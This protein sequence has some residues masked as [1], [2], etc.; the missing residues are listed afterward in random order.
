MALRV[1]VLKQGPNLT[2]RRVDERLAQAI[3]FCEEMCGKVD[4]KSLSL[5]SQN[6][7]FP[8]RM[9]KESLKRLSS[10]QN[11]ESLIL[12]NMVEADVL[13]DIKEAVDL[14][15][16]TS[17]RMRLDAKYQSGIEDILLLW[18][19]LPVPWV[20]KSIL[21]NS[22]ITVDEFRTVATSQGVFDDTFTYTPFTGFCT[23]HPSDPNA[24]LQ[25]DCYGAGVST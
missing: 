13:D 18:R 20:I 23:H 10:F 8:W 17:I 9:G 2:E 24:K 3:T 14:R 21:F 22:T 15:K 7:H 6:P 11:L 25:L 19:T 16:L 4:L 12:E 5:Y 1:D